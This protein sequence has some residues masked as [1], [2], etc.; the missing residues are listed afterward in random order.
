MNRLT[1]QVVLIT[2]GGSGLGRAIVERFIAEGARVG[3]LEKSLEK[4]AQLKADFR[5]A[6]SVCPGDVRNFT[7]NARAVDDVAARSNG[8]RVQPVTRP[9]TRR[10]PLTGCPPKR[11]G[12]IWERR[13][14][15][16]CPPAPWR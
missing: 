3:V 13:D 4:C 15:R 1:D 11:R 10:T 9:A 16:R 5:G 7:D 12:R 2:G 14:P 6:V 8:W